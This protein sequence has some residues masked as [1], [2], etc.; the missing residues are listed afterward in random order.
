MKKQFFFYVH[1]KL[2]Q[3]KVERKR[4]KTTTRKKKGRNGGRRGEK[5]KAGKK[6]EEDEGVFTEN[7]ALH[8]RA[9]EGFE[10]NVNKSAKK[11]SYHL[12]RRLPCVLM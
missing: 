11:S 3:L 5:S 1:C 4:T 8:K 7:G 12:C 6:K 10:K 2:Q 9:E